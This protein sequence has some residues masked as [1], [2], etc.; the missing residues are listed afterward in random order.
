VKY[1]V[2]SAAQASYPQVIHMKNKKQAMLSHF[3]N[4]L[5]WKTPSIHQTAS[6]LD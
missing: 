3:Q 4:P 2:L 1:I 6:R 5:T